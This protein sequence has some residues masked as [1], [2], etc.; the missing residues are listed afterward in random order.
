MEFKDSY[1]Q[2]LKVDV[3]SKMVSVKMFNTVGQH[4]A[5]FS[6]DAV[7]AEMLALRFKLAAKEAGK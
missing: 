3:R 4:T 2:T 1:G 5:S 6:F 7:T